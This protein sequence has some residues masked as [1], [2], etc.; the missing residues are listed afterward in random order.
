MVSKKSIIGTLQESSLHASLKKLYAQPGDRFEERVDGY[1]IDIV[2]ENLL[3]EVQT[4]SFG[5]IKKKL[6]NLVK[7]HKVKL[8]YP[9]AEKKWIVKYDRNN[10]FIERRKSPKK[11]SPFDIV[12]E[13]VSLPKILTHNNFEI[14]LVMIYEDEIRK[15]DGK[16]SWR[17]KGW[18]ISDHILMESIDTIQI[19]TP[20]DLMN[21]FPE[22]FPSKFTNFDLEL[23]FNLPKHIIQK[24]TYILNKMGVINLIGREGRYKQYQ[25]IKDNK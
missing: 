13:L 15:K 21:L 16:G 1:V 14:E 2:R 7:R 12:N 24:T 25:L 4:R 9:I 3:I 19:Q 18:S 6:W 5:S 20:K 11:G 10:N 23:L 8:V 22:K 17:R